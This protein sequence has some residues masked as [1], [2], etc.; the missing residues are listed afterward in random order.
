[1]VSPTGPSYLQDK[2]KSIIVDWAKKYR[3]MYICQR[4]LYPISGFTAGL[5][6]PHL[7]SFIIKIFTGS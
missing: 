1:V 2:T 3:K 6:L 4:L 7:V 5:I